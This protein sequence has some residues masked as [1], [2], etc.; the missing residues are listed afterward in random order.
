MVFDIDIASYFSSKYSDILPFPT[1]QLTTGNIHSVNSYLKYVN[2][3][4]IDHKLSERFQNLLSIVSDP[5]LLFTSHEATLLNDLDKQ[6]T[7][8]MLNGEFLCA[9]KAHSRQPWSPIQRTIARLFSYWKQKNN[10]A[11]KKMFNWHHLDQLWHDTD[12]SDYEHNVC[13]PS[14]IY[15]QMKHYRHKWRTTKK[16]SSSLHRAFLQECAKHRASNMNSTTEKA[17]K[18]ILHSEEV[19]GIYRNLKE[20]LGKQISSLT[21]VDITVQPDSGPSQT[22]A[23]N[24]K[25][26]MEEHILWHNRKHSLQALAMPFFADDRLHNDTDPENAS[27]QF[28]HILD[29]SYIEMNSSSFSQSQQEWIQSLQRILY[30]EISL[31][32]NVDKK[33]PSQTGMYCFIPIWVPHGSL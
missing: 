2:Q 14:F 33:N 21:Q 1:H 11:K 13:D 5:N 23:V 19:R 12:I 4:A 6:L 26:D 27:N 8:I 25:E 22:E 3:Q 17:L 10:M 18:A 28:D 32:L 20:L 7:D 9:K 15:N 24:H 16:K 29:G 30:S 31:D